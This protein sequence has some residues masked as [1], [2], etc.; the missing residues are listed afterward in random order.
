MNP[1]TLKQIA[2]YYDG[3]ATLFQQLAVDATGASV[4]APPSQAAPAASAGHVGAAQGSTFSDGTPIDEPEEWQEFAPAPLLKATQPTGDQGSLA[5]CPKHR[6]PYA[7]GRY[8]PYCKQ[9][10]DEGPDW[11]N[12]KGYCRI[13]P[14]N[15]GAWLRQ[16][17]GAAA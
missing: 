12:A 7:D 3:L 11:A 4:S 16:H 10:S 2:D 5:S 17:A 15:A 13:T 6:V 8:G 1:N 9:Q 14:K